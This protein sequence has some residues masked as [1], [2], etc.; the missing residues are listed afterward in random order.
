MIY[1]ARVPPDERFEAYAR[2]N[3]GEE[4]NNVSLATKE[5]IAGTI[6]PLHVTL[7]YISL[8]VLASAGIAFC[9]KWFNREETLFRT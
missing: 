6:Q 5:V 4:K 3:A 7:S 8:T 9:V 1:R 2:G